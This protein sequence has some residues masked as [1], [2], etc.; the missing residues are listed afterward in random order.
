[1]IFHPVCELVLIVV[2]PSR[3][4]SSL[5]FEMELDESGER[6]RWRE[7]LVPGAGQT[8]SG[9]CS[10]ERDNAV[11]DIDGVN[12]ELD[13]AVIARPRAPVARLRCSR[14]FMLMRVLGGEKAVMRRIA[15]IGKKWKACRKALRPFKCISI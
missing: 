14:S 9:V 13:L 6:I 2:V 4:A 8:D 12:G 7:L 1:M 15:I 10:A 3:G 5:T 11:D